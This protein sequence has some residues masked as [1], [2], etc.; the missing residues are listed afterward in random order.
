MASIPP[1]KPQD[2]PPTPKNTKTPPRQPRGKGGVFVSWDAAPR[3][4]IPADILRAVRYFLGNEAIYKEY[5]LHPRDGVNA[6][7][8]LDPKYPNGRTADSSG[9]FRPAWPARLRYVV[10]YV[11]GKDNA[12]T[13]ARILY[14]Y[15][16][17]PRA[18]RN[19]SHYAM[20]RKRLE[21]RE[22]DLEKMRKE[23]VK[24]RR[25]GLARA[26]KGLPRIPSREPF[27][28]EPE[29]LFSEDRAKFYEA[30]D[31]RWEYIAAH[32]DEVSEGLDRKGRAWF[33]HPVPLNG[34]TYSR[35]AFWD[36]K[37]LYDSLWQDSIWR[38]G[39]PTDIDLDSE[40]ATLLGFWYQ[41]GLGIKTVAWPSYK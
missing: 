3:V 32:W 36:Q 29:D 11:Y 19:P 8:N 28:M 37:M 33:G 27:S 17:D 2:K 30:T 12:D 14:I 10:K 6:V 15:K 41:M 21:R 4:S 13:R 24:R 23:N 25:E 34:F 16:Q 26:R 22:K 20:L 18:D 31:A 38:R 1:D 40:F 7:W 39:G 5:G 35:E 9:G